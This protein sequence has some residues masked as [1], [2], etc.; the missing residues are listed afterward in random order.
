MRYTLAIL[1]VFLFVSA[2]WCGPND[3]EILSVESQIRYLESQKRMSE[4]MERPGLRKEIKEKKR[5][6]AQLKGQRVVSEPSDD[7]PEYDNTGEINALRHKVRQLEIWR[8]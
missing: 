6:L 7:T 8:D 3:D 1:A 2:A 4:G 5:Y